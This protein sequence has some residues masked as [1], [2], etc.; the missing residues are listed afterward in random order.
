[1]AYIFLMAIFQRNSAFLT[2]FPCWEEILEQRNTLYYLYFMLSPCCD[3]V[4]N[5]L[6]KFS[7]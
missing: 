2:G 4:A 7:L 6:S 1:M 5:P 3:D